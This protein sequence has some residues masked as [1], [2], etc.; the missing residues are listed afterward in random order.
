MHCI[1]GVWE[2]HSQSECFDTP[3]LLTHRLLEGRETDDGPG[4]C[5]PDH[6]P[7]LL[8]AEV[9]GVL[10]DDEG[11][12][13]GVSR[14]PAG[15]NIVCAWHGGLE[16]DSRVVTSYIVHAV[17]VKLV[18]GVNSSQVTCNERTLRLST[19]DHYHH[20]TITNVVWSKLCGY[21][22]LFFQRLPARKTSHGLACN[23]TC[24]GLVWMLIVDTW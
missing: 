17:I 10:G 22:K 9:V 5:L 16:T 6:V 13:P 3:E 4:V 14:H 1:F 11:P 18:S 7:E 15:I 23:K 12:V 20:F 24:E 19:T 21:R 8:E 2:L